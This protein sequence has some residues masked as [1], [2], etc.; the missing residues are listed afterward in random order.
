MPNFPSFTEIFRTG[1]DEVLVR[2]A[3]VS[4]EAVEREGMDANILV[5]SAAAM[6]DEVVAQLS[7]LAAS[8]FLD[9]ATGVALDRL[10]YDRYSLTRKPAAAG[11]GSVSFTTTVA[12]P[13]TF[14]IPKGVIL[15]TSSG[16]Q[17]LTTESATFNIGSVGPLVVAV[18]STKA[19]ADQAAKIGTITSIVTQISGSPGDLTVSNSLATTGAD[20]VES[21]DSLRDRARRFFTTVQRGTAKAIELAALGVPGIRK[22]VVFEVI[23]SYGRPARAIQLVVTDSFTEQFMQYDVLPSRYQTQSQ[24]VAANVYQALAD[25]RP[26]GTYVQVIVANVVIQPVQLA[27]AFNA[28]A[29]VN[30]TALQARA[31]TVTYI[32][33]L[34]PGEPFQTSALL[35][36]L[37]QIPGLSFTGGEIVSP[38][39]NIVPKPTQVIRA[40]L[41]VISAVAAQTNNPI[42]TGSN[43]DVY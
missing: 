26:A 11:I 18:R 40:S 8:L 37:R 19:G 14:S 10:V 15:Q 33:G 39:G 12:S 21:D 43:P 23:D 9:S 17:Y 20:D 41:A 22:A 2:N 24:A 25:V 42:I 36:V 3:K 38:T 31:A 5:A 6:G 1:R 27:L 7:E 32:N 28:G 16:V 30:N 4:R 13:V 34:K 29:N 35:A